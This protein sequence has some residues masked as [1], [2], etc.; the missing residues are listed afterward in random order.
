M[1]WLLLVIV[2]FRNRVPK[3]FFVVNL[4]QLVLLL[5]SLRWFNFWQLVF[6]LHSLRRLVF[7][8]NRWL[9]VQCFEVAEAL[10]VVLNL[11]VGD[12]SNGG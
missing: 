10:F 7:L 4:R 5:V 6:L 12:R 2:L 8:L 11:N 1:R 3:R 9:L